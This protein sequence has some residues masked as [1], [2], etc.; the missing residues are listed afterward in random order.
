MN[1]LQLKLDGVSAVVDAVHGGRL[2]SLSVGGR[3]LLAGNLPGN[4]LHWGSY[5]MVPWVGR[6]RRG[7]FSFDGVDY[8][9][10]INME[11]HAI[12]GTG[13]T[14]SWTVTRF[15]S[16]A[17][18]IETPIGDGDGWPFPGVAR[19]R[20]ELEAA[21]LTC[22]IEVHATVRMPS[23][24]G[25]HPWFVKPDA[26]DFSPATMYRRDDDYVCTSETI[27]PPTPPPW[28]DCFT[29]VPQPV[30]LTWGDFTLEI[31]SSCDHWVLYDMPEHATCAEPQSGP[32]NSLN[33]G[34][35]IVEPGEP[36]V[37]WMRL[38]WNR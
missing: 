17:L 11:P 18:E 2:A 23:S 31:T 12:H 3:E 4:P 14:R 37:H 32:S 34:A 5:P 35:T 30:S 28:D 15:G 9:L 16:D 38:A 20:F 22:W 25:W 21:S 33:L 27:A 19:Q 7:R 26:V 8:E 29:D 1:P 24:I 6:T 36:F 13:F 10:P